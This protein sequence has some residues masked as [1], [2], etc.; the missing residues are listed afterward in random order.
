MFIVQSLFDVSD[1]YP[2]KI[3]IKIIRIEFL[4]G[5]K[6]HEIVIQIILLPYKHSSDPDK[7]PA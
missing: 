6:I 3:W 1:P 2:L 7:K 5:E 4:N